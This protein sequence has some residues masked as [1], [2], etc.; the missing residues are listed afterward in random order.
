[1]PCGTTCDQQWKTDLRACRMAGHLAGSLVRSLDP[2]AGRSSL[3]VA[4]THN[5]SAMRPARLDFAAINAAALRDLPASCC[6]AQGAFTD[7]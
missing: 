4:L 6:T 5:A 1:M 2:N 7:P 3:M